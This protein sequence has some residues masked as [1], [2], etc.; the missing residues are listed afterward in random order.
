MSSRNTAVI[1]VLA[2]LVAA[3]ALAWGAGVFGATA[4]PGSV[5]AE[6]GALRRPSGVSQ[7]TPGSHRPADPDADR[8]ALRGPAPVPAPSSGSKPTCNARCVGVVQD[9]AE[10]P[11]PGAT[12]RFAWL[13]AG[14]LRELARTTSDAHGRF[15]FDLQPLADLPSQQLDE[16]EIL[17]VATCPGWLPDTES[18]LVTELQHALQRQKDARTEIFL[19]PG[20][21]LTG[22]VLDV[23]GAP[24]P[25]AEVHWSDKDRYSHEGYTDPD[26]VFVVPAPLAEAYPC[27]FTAAAP[28][29]GVAVLRLTHPPRSGQVPELVL[30]SAA[31]LQGRI[32][33]VAGEPPAK[34]ALR[35][36]R[37]LSQRERDRMLL[38]VD[39]E[40]ISR[41]YQRGDMMTD[42]EGRYRVAGV[43]RGRYRIS[44]RNRIGDGENSFHDFIPLVPPASTEDGATN[45]HVV[46]PVT[47]RVEAPE[48]VDPRLT[49]L[50]LSCT[51]KAMA[52][53]L[54]QFR[55]GT[56]T[57]V[58]WRPVDW[59]SFIP[60]PLAN[61]DYGLLVPAGSL[62]MAQAL[63]R[64]EGYCLHVTEVLADKRSRILLRFP[65]PEQCG[66][67]LVRVLD[68]RG[69]QFRPRGACLRT[70]G[71]FDV[72]RWSPAASSPERR[73][74]TDAQ[75]R[76]M[77]SFPAGSYRLDVPM[78]VLDRATA[79][80]LLRSPET[81]LHLGT[82]VE[83]ELHA[84]KETPVTVRLQEGGRVKLF[85][86]A[87]GKAPRASA[88][89]KLTAR[90][91][92]S[93]QELSLRLFA[94]D[95]GVNGQ[96]YTGCCFNAE[97]WGLQ[98]LAPG[99]WRFRLELN[100][101]APTEL[102]GRVT[103]GR[104]CELRFHLRDQPR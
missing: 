101:F 3:C 29:L 95:S 77:G 82:T 84:G 42:G 94:H 87:T 65:G 23:R 85:L 64:T 70:A 58:R 8:Q 26:G 57:P 68:S 51:T 22:R 11:I 5:P 103:P 47:V 17:L 81:R 15:S 91:V 67:L 96:V 55:A 45:V 2:L 63:H 52:R 88:Y 41:G 50:T 79:L 86:Q 33:L 35:Y 59:G 38:R 72:A 73:G 56:L 37:V 61:H 14:T 99:T 31:V 90:H 4:G 1:L 100:G 98:P 28:R 92:S 74:N 13:Q 10:Q 21:T 71:G 78:E 80:A 27:D 36:E 12:I 75:G 34:I 18:V 39:F 19:E 93:G 16:S 104:F 48:A 97:V 25:G 20:Q 46:Q 54:Q 6:H 62:W 60:V 43:R 89:P 49:R 102:M 30:R 40:D 83:L 9:E 69:R 53:K 24:V 32:E 76:L 44:V 66:R 7:P